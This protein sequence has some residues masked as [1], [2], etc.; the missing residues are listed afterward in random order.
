MC[1]ASCVAEG[2]PPTSGHFPACLSFLKSLPSTEGHGVPEAEA[3][4]GEPGPAGTGRGEDR[5]GHSHPWDLKPVGPFQ[6]GKGG[7]PWGHNT[8]WLPG[9][10][11]HKS[12]LP[13]A[14]VGAWVFPGSLTSVTGLRATRTI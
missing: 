4:S 5:P 1:V 14:L 7:G 11:V 2:R 10:S 13:K 8:G 6:C 3:T 9:S 12:H